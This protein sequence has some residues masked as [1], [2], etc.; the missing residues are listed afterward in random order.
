ML[1]PFIL[2]IVCFRWFLELITARQR[3]DSFVLSRSEWC[4]SRQRSWGVPIP[5]LYDRNGIP[6]LST[7]SLDHIISVLETKGMD[8]WWTGD[9]EDFIPDSHRGQDLS[10]G[11]DTLD[12]WFDSG[13]SWTLLEKEVPRDASLPLADVYLEGSDQHRGWFQSSLLTRLAAEDG[14][15]VAPYKHLITHGFVMDGDGNKM[16]KSAGNGTSPM[17]IVNGGGVRLPATPLTVETPGIWS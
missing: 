6:L 7:A 5:A 11:I 13:S 12:V 15:A 4:I 17:D 8:H 14:R 9:V 1:S 10:R 3:L 16:S 2:H